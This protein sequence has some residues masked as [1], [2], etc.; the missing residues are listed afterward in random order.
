[1][2]YIQTP[3]KLSMET[4]KLMS[5]LI[6]RVAPSPPAY[7]SHTLKE[8]GV[9]AAGWS[10]RVLTSVVEMSGVTGFFPADGHAQCH[11]CVGGWH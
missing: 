9:I 7:V 10:A 5:L 3:K 11:V 6:L 2:Q 1:M 8:H 4:P